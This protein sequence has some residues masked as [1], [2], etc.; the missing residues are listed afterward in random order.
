MAEPVSPDFD[1]LRAAQRELNSKPGARSAPAKVIPVPNGLDPA[2]AALAAAPYSALWDLDAPDHAGWRAIAKRGDAA[3]EPL[4]AEARTRLGVEI[5][6]TSVGGVAAFLLTPKD[7]PD[8]HKHQLVVNLHGGGFIFG[9][10]EAG[11]AEAMLLA[12]YGGYK[13]LAIDYRMPPDA[14]Y[15]AA[16][17][18]VTAVWRALVKTVDPRRIA[19]EGTSAGGGLTLSLMLRAKAEGLPMPGAIAP[20]SP[21]A[22]LTGAGDSFN[23]NAW[24]DNVVV[25]PEGYM[26]RASDLYVGGGDRCDPML[27][28][29]YGDFAGLPPAILTT[30]TRD[31][32]LS[33]TVRVHRKLRRA[34]VCAEL[35]VHEALSHAQY[36]FDP[37]GDLPREV[38]REIA[39]FFDLYLAS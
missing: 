31:L 6:P 12:A 19:I 20:G 29:L 11:T 37:T 27:S 16:L 22:D 14:P 2:T 33:D 15:P 18:D 9:A 32:L 28:P 23:T 34:G 1:L 24:I 38:F 5:E 4:L 25:S 26:R 13:V 10:G 30:G 36:N 3:Q 39:R 8:A 35:H 17:D 7:L 21:A